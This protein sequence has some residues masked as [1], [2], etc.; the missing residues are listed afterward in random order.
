MS[1]TCSLA[2]CK[3]AKSCLPVWLHTFVTPYENKTT[4]ARAR[5]GHQ[6]NH[7]ISF[8]SITWTHAHYLVWISKAK[9]TRVGYFGNQSTLLD[10]TGCRLLP[11]KY[12]QQMTSRLK[13]SYE[14]IQSQ[15]GLGKRRSQIFSDLLL[16]LHL[17]A[18]WRVFMRCFHY[19]EGAI[20]RYTTTR[21]QAWQGWATGQRYGETMR[22]RGMYWHTPTCTHTC[23]QTNTQTD[24]Q[25]GICLCICVFVCLCYST[26]RHT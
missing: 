21:S 16:L 6:T 20:L 5:S 8:W 3:E 23:I 15:C 12:W 2:L 14:F 18:L 10:A 1:V 26:Y 7:Q 9:F 13:S 22:D 19:T 17:L 24:T 4:P 25:L 11:L